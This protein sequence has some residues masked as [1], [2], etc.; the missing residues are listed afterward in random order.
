MPKRQN[1][2]ITD[3]ESDK[4][5]QEQEKNILI[6]SLHYAPYSGVGAAR[7]T[8]FSEYLKKRGYDVTVVCYAETAYSEN[9]LLRKI[10][11]GIR[12]ITVFKERSKVK[13][14]VNLKKIIADLLE[15]RK[16][17]LFIV[18]VGPFIPYFFLTELWM[19]YKVPYIIDYRDHWLFEHATVEC[20]VKKYIRRVCEYFRM[21]IEKRVLKYAC[22][23]IFV[24]E[25]SKKIIQKR[26]EL[27]DEKCNVVYNG[28]DLKTLTRIDNNIK[29][30][31]EGL[32]IYIAG[33][34]SSYNPVTAK[35]F[36]SICKKISSYNKVE[37]F[38][39]GKPEEDLYEYSEIYHEL[40]LMDY[41]K[42]INEL[43]KADVLL[44]S[45]EII[46]GLGTKTFDYL[47]L[48]KPIIYIG[49]VASEL[50]EFLLQ[51]ENAYICSNEIQMQDA[52]EKLLNEC[53]DIL[54]SK[55]ID[56]YS[57]ERQNEIYLSIIKAI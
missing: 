6:I 51:F 40:G 16:Y 55:N 56:E 35:M 50:S 1:V 4:K 13:D 41:E 3:L 7:M 22:K 5:E 20:G 53:P 14:I 12:R 28:F 38:H 46:M 2:E 19:K 34:F 48:N 24:S 23:I 36:L 31:N 25:K 17:R 10:P 52:I 30:R 33:K 32:K 54:T 11:K 43:R 29:K 27:P 18:S 44:V 37:V 42:T 47:Y 21:P 26:Y 57:R 15:K 45:N 8:S 9:E 49:I 39:I